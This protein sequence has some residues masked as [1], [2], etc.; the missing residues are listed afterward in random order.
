MLSFV[1]P[2]AQ[3]TFFVH[4]NIS[5]CMLAV[6]SNE[7]AHW[8]LGHKL[9]LA[10]M[11]MC[12]PLSFSTWHSNVLL[13][14]STGEKASHYQQ[15][16]EIRHIWEKLIWIQRFSALASFSHDSILKNKPGRSFY[17]SLLLEMDLCILTT[18]SKK[19]FCTALPLSCTGLYMVRRQ[20]DSPIATTRVFNLLK[21]ASVQQ[22]STEHV[23]TCVS[24]QMLHISI[25]H[26][27]LSV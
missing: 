6:T 13:S 9:P 21:G 7:T 14:S 12:R 4:A 24:S 11:N 17:P 23:G 5:I 22:D 1:T 16:R 25:K 19:D 2:Y 10:F 26:F 15:P 18:T 3:K 27:K 8:K 20:G